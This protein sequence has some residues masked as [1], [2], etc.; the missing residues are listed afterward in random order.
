MPTKYFPTTISYVQD[1]LT[2][3]VRRADLLPPY[4][5]IFRL[6]DLTVW[7]L[8][9]LLVIL[10]GIMLF[11]LSKTD[12]QIN[13]R[14]KNIYYMIL[15]I[16]APASAGFTINRR[17]MPGAVLYR[18][19]IILIVLASYVGLVTWS[20]FLT[21]TTLR[22]YRLDQV[23]N[24]EGLLDQKFDLSSTRATYTIICEQKKVIESL[25]WK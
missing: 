14:N 24:I 22:T 9:A 19:Y 15:L 11:V 6:T 25:E 2:W 13:H 17:L 4:L 12:P 8:Y 5:N 20:S 1:D 16:A 10:T 21:L 3:C 7:C 18:I 23:T